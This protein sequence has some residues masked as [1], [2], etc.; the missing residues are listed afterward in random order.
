MRIEADVP[1]SL[2]HLAAELE[3]DDWHVSWVG[4]ATVDV[5][6]PDGEWDSPFLVRI[7][8]SRFLRDWQARYPGAAVELRLPAGPVQPARRLRGV[9]PSPGP[10]AGR[11][12]LVPV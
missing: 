11:P 12:R 3:A 4:A 5:R 7:A 9:S 1:E 2:C 10:S 6:P 8:L